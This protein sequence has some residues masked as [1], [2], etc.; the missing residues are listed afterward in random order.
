MTALTEGRATPEIAGRTRS[1]IVAAGVRIFGGAL[2][3]RNAAGEILPAVAALGLVGIGRAEREV[4]NR[5][6]EAGDATVE[7]DQGT[8]RFATAGG[9]D[10]IDATDVGALVFMVDDQT[11]GATDGGGS[12]SP[13]GIVEMVDDLGAWVRFDEVLTRIA[14]A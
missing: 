3:A 5:D 8:F 12:R 1:G 7:F 14:A 10:A 9:A 11:V 4:D 2:V 13:A 6:G